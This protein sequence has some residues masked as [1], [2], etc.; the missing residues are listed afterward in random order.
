[1]NTTYPT[2]TLHV[3]FVRPDGSLNW[4]FSC[5]RLLPAAI[6]GVILHLILTRLVFHPL[7]NVPGPRLAG[8]TKWYE[9]YYDVVCNGEYLNHIELMHATYS[10]SPRVCPILRTDTVV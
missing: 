1:M 2:R 3:H 6:F 9:F 10:M 8:L 4:D 7:A 5:T